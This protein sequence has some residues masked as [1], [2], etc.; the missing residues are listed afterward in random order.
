MFRFTTRQLLLATTIVA[1]V[2]AGYL[3]YDRLER[4]ARGHER[5]AELVAESREVLSS[6]STFA[7][8]QDWPDYDRQERLH[9]QLAREYRQKIWRPW[10][11][12]TQPSPPLSIQIEILRRADG[13]R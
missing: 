3:R 12:V 11:R 1:V 13:D 4:I 8:V 5:Q 6:V 9:Q 2:L 7:F 10:M